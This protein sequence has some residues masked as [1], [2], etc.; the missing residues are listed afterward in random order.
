ML[1][2]L[3]ALLV[4]AAAALV[5]GSL[6]AATPAGG[7]V[8][9][10]RP[11]TGIEVGPEP[12]TTPTTTDPTVVDGGEKEGG[13]GFFDIP[14]RIK[15]AINDWFRDLVTSALDPVL[16]LLGRTILATPLVT[17]PGRVRDLWGTSAV[18]ANTAMGLL[19]LVGA[20]IAMTHET[21]QTRYGLK[22]V[23]PR[24]VVAVI[25][26]NASLGLS[27]QAITVANALSRAFLGTEVEA[28][29]ASLGMKALVMGAISGGGIF[30]V[31][32]GGVAAALAL[33]LLVVYVVRVA[34]VILLVA[35]GPLALSAHA[36]P[37]TDGL[38]RLWWRALAGLLAIQVGQALV[39]VAAL[40]VFFAA[41][42]RSTL[43]LSAG[44]TLVD[45]LIVLTLLWVLLRIP[46]W[47]GR[48]VFSSGRVNA[49]VRAVKTVVVYRAARAA[50]AGG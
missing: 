19:A 46:V 14:G 23:A 15:K 44:G 49:T 40:R 7:Q 9:D 17:G 21:L 11:P 6:T 12:P 36:L 41:D 22:E 43:G 29:E 30:L 50:V 26:A 47:V 24:L 10:P 27:G 3:L 35:A 34:L 45:L 48:A 31:L 39:F 28:Q 2:R 42:G 13:P 25:A 33:A 37:H 20:A 16:E 4:L 1:A 5:V 38:A 8:G 32:I 18:V